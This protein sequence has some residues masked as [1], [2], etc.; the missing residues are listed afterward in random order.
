MSL[1]PMAYSSTMCEVFTGLSKRPRLTL[2]V[3]TSVSK[4]RVRKLTDGT[5]RLLIN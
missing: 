3:N 5:V 1:P 2:A 4:Q